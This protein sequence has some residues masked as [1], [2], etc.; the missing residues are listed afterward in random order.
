[1]HYYLNNTMCKESKNTPNMNII[2]APSHST[3][4]KTDI[5]ISAGTKAKAPDRIRSSAQ[6]ISRV[7][8]NLAS[9]KQKSS[10]IVQPVNIDSPFNIQ[11]PRL[12]D[13]LNCSFCEYTFNY[14]SILNPSTAVYTTHLLPLYTYPSF[15]GVNS[16]KLLVFKYK[17]KTNK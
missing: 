17:K 7:R 15:L 16:M 10:S 1:M 12:D 8:S 3:S 4:N 11:L 6:T 13:P 14:I 9:L 5:R 2:A